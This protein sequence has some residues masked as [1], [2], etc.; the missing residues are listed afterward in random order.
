MDKI[1]LKNGTVIEI[2]ESSN[3][4][5]FRKA[6]T[7]AQEFISVLEELNQDNLS[8][9]QIQNAAGLVCANPEN[10]ECLT[11][12]VTAVWTDDGV[13]SGLDVTFYITDVD[14][15]AKEINELQQ[16]LAIHSEAISELAAIIGGE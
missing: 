14:M 7:S 8:S 15:R 12:N 11:Q 3:S 9:Y 16:D 6:F 5:N 13:L 4:G 10:K 1:I 2:E